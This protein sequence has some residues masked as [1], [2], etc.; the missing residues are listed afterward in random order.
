MAMMYCVYILYSSKAKK[1]Y[2]G[3]TSNLEQRVYYQNKSRSPF[4]KMKGPWYPVYSEEY[5]TRS[6]AMI[7]E[8]EIKSWKSSKKIIEELNIN[9]DKIDS[10]GHVAMG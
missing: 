1:L 2:I 10:S 9:I 7:R 4:T 6:E 3:A 5:K 8:R